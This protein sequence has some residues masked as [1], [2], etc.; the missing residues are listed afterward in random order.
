MSEEKLMKHSLNDELNTHDEYVPRLPKTRRNAAIVWTPR[1][2]KDYK[3]NPP[4]AEAF[5]AK[6]KQQAIDIAEWLGVFVTNRSDNKPSTSG[7]IDHVIRAGVAVDWND[8]EKL[9]I[10]LETGNRKRSGLNDNELELLR[11]I[12]WLRSVKRVLIVPALRPGDE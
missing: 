4:L 3:H 5:V 2:P 10:D 9:M 6:V 11:T 12:A 1:I 8:L 7:M